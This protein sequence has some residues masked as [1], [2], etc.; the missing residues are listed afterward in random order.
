MAGTLAVVY[1][2]SMS[3]TESCI[4]SWLVGHNKE[5]R[6][7][8]SP[9]RPDP[10]A[11]G[12]Q[13]S[14]PQSTSGMLRA[15]SELFIRQHAALREKRTFDWLSGIFADQLPNYVSITTRETLGARCQ[16]S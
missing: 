2:E 10:T 4:A 3:P 16:L 11:E 12:W 8:W 15:H 6:L 9:V 5:K 14:N 7:R 13:L 1:H